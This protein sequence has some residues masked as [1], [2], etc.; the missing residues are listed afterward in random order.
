[1]FLFAKIKPTRKFF[2]RKRIILILSAAVLV[3]AGGASISVWTKNKSSSQAQ[4]NALQTATVQRGSIKLFASGTGTLIS[5]TQATFGF[6]TSGTVVEVSVQEGDV[7]EAGQLLARLDDTS[8]QQ[9]YQQA[10][11]ALAELTSPSAIAT[12]QLEVADDKTAVQDARAT[13]AYLISPEVLYWEEQ[14]TQAQQDLQKAKDEAAANP[15]PEADRKVQDAQKTVNFAQANLDQARLDYWND[16]VPDTFLTVTVEGHTTVKKVIAPSETVIDAARAQYALAKAQLQ[17]AEDYLTAI[18]TG[19]IPQNATG[20]KIAALEQAQQA[21]Q[22]AQDAVEAT[23][24]YAPI[25]GTILSMGFAVG[26]MVGSSST[27]TI[28]N[29][30]QPY[31][32]EIFLD[33]SDWSNIQAGYPVEVTFDLLPDDVYTGKVISVDPE[34]M[35]TNGSLYIHATVVLDTNVKTVLPFGTSASVDVIGGE[36][37]N[38]LLVPIE[39]LHE[40]SAGQY[41]VFVIVDGKPQVRSVEI[42]LQDAT[43]A[44]VKSGLKEGDVVTT[45]ITETKS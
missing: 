44:E 28:A 21:V 39:A 26:D 45:G 22:T 23:K 11:S 32:L 41:M 2:S 30:D 5:P 1:M 9:Q 20:A 8:A 3:I 25:H 13:L 10:L 43:R 17:E 40:V 6:S 18:T 36:A 19:T 35:N 12:A 16:Y 7:V 29:L 24:L 14:L 31:T 34:L 42:G 38:V 15:S 4:Q 27:V 37:D 33:Q